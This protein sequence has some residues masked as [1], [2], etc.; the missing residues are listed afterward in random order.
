LQDRAKIEPCKQAPGYD[1]LMSGQWLDPLNQQQMLVS[2]RLALDAEEIVRE[3]VRPNRLTAEE[4]A[5]F[6]EDP[7]VALIL[8]PDGDL[9]GT[10]I[11]SEGVVAWVKSLT[12]AQAVGW[13]WNRLEEDHYRRFLSKGGEWWR[14]EEWAGR[15]P[16]WYEYTRKDGKRVVWGQKK[17]I[18]SHSVEELT[19]DTLERVARFLVFHDE[20]KGSLAS[21]PEGSLGR[22]IRDRILESRAAWV[23]EGTISPL[24]SELE[25]GDEKW[26]DYMRR[27]WK[28]LKEGFMEN[29]YEAWRQGVA[30]DDK[31]G[32]QYYVPNKFGWKG[33]AH[34]TM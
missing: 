20:G 17:Q 15:P 16:Y 2:E 33:P 9:V 25:A 6:E 26:G 3:L 10:Y 4:I 31:I 1:E 18:M 22:Y 13:F 29:S 23:A 30:M 28:E 21:Q 14:G 11:G 7:N 19:S 34:R 24:V 8:N 27:K 5:E 32:Q 12:R